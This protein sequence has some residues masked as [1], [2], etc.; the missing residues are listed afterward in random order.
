MRTG[1]IAL[2]FV[3]GCYRANFAENVPC[4]ADLTCPG[5]QVCNTFHSPPICVG[6]LGT[7]PGPWDSGTTP[8]DSPISACGV[9]EP[10]TPVCDPDSVTCRGCYRDNECASDV[11]IESNG[12]CVPE[13]NA[14]YV[15]PNGDDANACT[16]NAPCATISRAVTLVDDNHFAIKVHD[17]DYDDSWISTGSS[18]VVSGENDGDP[19]YISFR[20]IAGHVHLVEVQGG[21]VV[22]ENV[23]LDGAPQETVRVESATVGLFGTDIQGG[24][25][26]GVD[27]Q[28]STVTLESIEVHDVGGTVAAVRFAE[29]TVLLS[30][31]I[32]YTVQGACVRTVNSLYT[33]ENSIL[34]DCMAAGFVQAGPVVNGSVFHFNTVSD[35][36]TGATCGSAVPL[37]SSIFANNGTASPQVTG[38]TSTYSLF[39]DMAPAGVGNLSMANPGFVMPGGDDH[40]T[41]QSAARNKGD[42]AATLTSDIDGESRP[43]GAGYDIGADEYH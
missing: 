15:R 5:G 10:S 39:S 9:C 43:N 22:I 25:T 29:S 7:D 1:A 24:A 3:A 32:V 16:R 41:F 8:P 23:D 21:T 20:A 27:V 6:S 36:G 35:N 14:L 38:C 17:G 42:P 40:I 12:T 11:C 13:A 33:I 19:G 18:Y 34:A 31:S 4:S 30:R 26:G 28:S 37:N 2:I